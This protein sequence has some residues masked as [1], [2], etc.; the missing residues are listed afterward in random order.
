VVGGDAAP[1][2]STTDGLNDAVLW[3]YG[4][5][6]DETVRAYDADTGTLLYTSPGL[7]GSTHWISPIIAKG[8][9]YVAQNGTVTALTVR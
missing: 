8:R 6:G 1:I 4:A 5:S 3:T 9:L 7:A 2:V